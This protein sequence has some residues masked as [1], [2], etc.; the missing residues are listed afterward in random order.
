MIAATVSSNTYY[1]PWEKRT[2]AYTGEQLY[3]ICKLSIAASKDVLEIAT[4]AM[5]HDRDGVL[6]QFGQL[7]VKI[8]NLKGICTE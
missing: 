2:M 4:F 6:R 5:R 3:E 1:L 8:S 7:Q